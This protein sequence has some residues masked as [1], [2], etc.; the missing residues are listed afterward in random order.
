MRKVTGNNKL[1]HFLFPHVAFFVRRFYKEFR[2]KGFEKIGK[3]EAVI[4]APNHQAAFMDA[5]VML[6]GVGWKNQLSIL[7]RA[8]IFKTK[9][10]AYLLNKINLMPVFRRDYDGAENLDKNDVIFDNCV[11]LLSD[12]KYLVLFPEATHN[13]QR[14]FIPLKKGV[15]RIAFATEEKNQ[16]QLNLKIYPVGIYY[17]NPRNF[18]EKVLV[19]VGEPVVVREF[20][21]VYQENPAKAHTMVKSLLEQRIRELMID[22][23]NEEFYDT[24]ERL[25]L[26]DLNEK[27]LDK[28]VEDFRNSK[29]LIAKSEQWVKQHPED[30]AVLK[31]ETWEYFDILDHAE[32]KDRHLGPQA[33]KFNLVVEGLL[34]LLLSPF[35]VIGWLHSYLPFYL[36]S[37]MVKKK[38]KDPGF[39][40]S[41]KAA[42]SAF[43]FPVMHLL[44]FLIFWIVSGSFLKSVLWVFLVLIS[45]EIAIWSWLRLVEIRH[46]LRAEKFKSSA[47]FEKAMGLRQSIVKKLRSFHS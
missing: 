36:P 37:R 4:L 7:V 27:S 29:V 11:E 25:R 5:L 18:Y 43:I 41:I 10:A 12:K 20:E 44:S 6:D 24:I 16:F 1:Y 26:I 33:P 34:L 22:I 3:D 38:I 14:R 40:S 2:T 15:T 23:R 42:F 8:S 35:M 19:Q 39:Y 21:S 17:T 45:T 46:F 32:V 30:A 9:T 47:A 13:L 31:A 28:V